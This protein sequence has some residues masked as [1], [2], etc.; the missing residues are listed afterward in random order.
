M[1]VSLSVILLTHNE[2]LHLGR[3]LES[4]A[5]FAERVIVVDSGSTDA[6]IDIARR[7]GATVLHNPWVNYAQQF[8]W[9]LEHAEVRTQWV[10]RLDADEVIGADLAAEIEEKLPQFGPDVAGINL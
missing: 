8:A 5:P 9:A 3:A 4:V 1:T 10:M 7:H 6:T 2:E